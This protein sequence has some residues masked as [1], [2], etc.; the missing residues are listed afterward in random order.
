MGYILVAIIVVCITICSVADRYFEYK[1][2]VEGK[3]KDD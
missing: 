3:K 2:K 1:E